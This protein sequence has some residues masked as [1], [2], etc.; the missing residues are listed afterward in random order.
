MADLFSHMQVSDQVTILV[1]NKDG[2]VIQRYDSAKKPFFAM[3]KAFIKYLI[4]GKRTYNSM[5]NAGF[6]VTSSLIYGSGTGFT[7]VAIGTGTTAAAAT[8]TTLQTET[9]RKAGTTS[10]VT[11]TVT[12][13]TSQWDA[14]FSSS[15]GLSG[16]AAITETGI[17]NNNTS[18]G[19]L[20][21]RQTFSAINVNW[22]NGDTLQMI[23]KCKSEQ[24]A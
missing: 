15:D 21:L 1:K 16:T 18:G 8:D 5:T 20:L 12:N 23:V 9:K 2:K 22:D 24:G 17:L 6:G 7:A 4:T 10:Q 13:D 19:V 14:T 11:T 3:A